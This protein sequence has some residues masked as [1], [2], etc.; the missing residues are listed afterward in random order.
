[1]NDSVILSHY[2]R[3][4]TYSTLILQI[5]FVLVLIIVSKILRRLTVHKASSVT[6]VWHE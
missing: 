3:Q 5:I 2:L 4:V 6:F 1:M